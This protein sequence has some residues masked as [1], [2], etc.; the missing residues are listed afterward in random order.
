MQTIFTAVQYI[1]AYE[2]AVLDLMATPTS[3]AGDLA[4][5]TQRAHSIAADAGLPVDLIGGRYPAVV[6][7]SVFP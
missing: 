7:F 2:P 4:V 5:D 1:V 3:L 6:W